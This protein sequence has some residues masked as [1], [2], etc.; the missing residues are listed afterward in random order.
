[1]WADHS[2]RRARAN[3]A[4]GGARHAAFLGLLLVVG[5]APGD[6]VVVVVGAAV[7]QFQ[8]VVDLEG[9][10]VLG[11]L[12]AAVDAGV[13]VAVEDAGAGAPR[14]PGVH[15]VIVS[16]CVARHVLCGRLGVVGL[17]APEGVVV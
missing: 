5:D 10:G 12:V 15:R 17:V 14:W 1:M 8:V 2:G 4:G 9:A 7:G 3:R 11:L 16:L 6:Q 13:V